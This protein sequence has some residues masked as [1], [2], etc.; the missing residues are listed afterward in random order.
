MTRVY[1]LGFNLAKGQGKSGPSIVPIILTLEADNTLQ[2]SGV[3]NAPVWFTQADFT[4]T[5]G[6]SDIDFTW[7]GT[8]WTSSGSFPSSSGRG[9]LTQGSDSHTA[10]YVNATAETYNILAAAGVRLTGAG[11]VLISWSGV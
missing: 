5:V 8:E 11:G 6:G 3:A 2:P 9:T 7:T 10:R 4:L 1:A